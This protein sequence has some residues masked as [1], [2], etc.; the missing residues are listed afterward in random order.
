[1]T[2]IK[3]YEYVNTATNKGVAYGE[4]TFNTDFRDEEGYILFNE[5]EDTFNAV[6]T[7]YGMIYVDGMTAPRYSRDGDNKLYVEM[8]LDTTDKILDVTSVLPTDTTANTDN[9]FAD[10]Q[11]SHGYGVR[12]NEYLDDTVRGWFV[13]NH[14]YYAE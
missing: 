7:F 5:Y 4:L 8:N 6:D 14:R 13:N 9:S 10:D 12:V 1:M 2:D 3:Y 11:W